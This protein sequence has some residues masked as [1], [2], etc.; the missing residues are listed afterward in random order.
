MLFGEQHPQKVISKFP[1]QCPFQIAFVIES[2]ATPTQSNPIATTQKR[3]DAIKMKIQPSFGTITKV[4]NVHSSFVYKHKTF[5][6]KTPRP[7][8]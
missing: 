5:K 4:V 8:G 2:S 1:R 7:K 6:N 3:I